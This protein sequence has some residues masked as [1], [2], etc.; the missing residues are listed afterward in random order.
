MTGATFRKRARL[1]ALVA[2]GALAVIAAV[3]ALTAFVVVTHW[4]T[5]PGRMIQRVLLTWAPTPF[6]LWSLWSVR[7]MFRALAREGL[8]FAPALAAALTRIGWGLALGAL[9][10]IL[11][12]PFVLALS[13]GGG[14]RA[15]FATF[16]VPALT[17]GVVGLALT[18][19]A[20]LLRRG[21]EVETELGEFV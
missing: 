4:G 21:A 11:T 9:T 10:T 19:S 5:M 7:T 18:A 6:Y 20:H 2:T 14:M 16:N 15:G 3:I 17:L 12:S 13:A 8:T 1:F